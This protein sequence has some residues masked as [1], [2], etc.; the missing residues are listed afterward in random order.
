MCGFYIKKINKYK[1]LAEVNILNNLQTKYTPLLP[2]INQMRLCSLLAYYD[3]YYYFCIFFSE[4][5][6]IPNSSGKGYIWSLIMQKLQSFFS[7]LYNLVS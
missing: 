3:K 4:I 5:I 1:L 7:V 6:K 2:T